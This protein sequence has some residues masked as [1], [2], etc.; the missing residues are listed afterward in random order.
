M[1]NF[2][3]KAANILCSLAILAAPLAERACR[4][5]FYEPEQPEG[6]ADFVRNNKK[7]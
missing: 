2:L 4:T 7:K 5:I 1:K 6:L 3:L